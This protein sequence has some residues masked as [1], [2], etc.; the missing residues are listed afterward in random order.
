MSGKRQELTP[1]LEDSNKYQNVKH[2]NV[3]KTVQALVDAVEKEGGVELVA[4]E[5]EINRV[6]M[7]IRQVEETGKAAIL[8]L[9]TEYSTEKRDN[10][11]VTVTSFRAAFAKK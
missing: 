3:E 2:V 9:K 8:S 4:R 11:E 10:R 6:G 7:V 1:V 5:G